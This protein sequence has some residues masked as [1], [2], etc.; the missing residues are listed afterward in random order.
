MVRKTRGEGEQF[1]ETSGEVMS[2]ACRKNTKLSPPQGVP[3]SFRM[4]HDNTP[5]QIEMREQCDRDTLHGATR[6]KSFRREYAS[7]LE[8]LH[9]DISK[10][11]HLQLDASYD[12]CLDR[13]LPS[14]AG[15]EK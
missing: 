12:S 3:L 2:S 5:F 9:I 15:F 13:P 4:A 1:I 11:R 7:I 10:H 14:V 6:L 8:G